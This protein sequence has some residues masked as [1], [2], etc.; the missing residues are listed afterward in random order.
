MTDL[1]HETSRGSPPRCSP[2]ESAQ[3]LLECVRR[4]EPTEPFLRAIAE[5]TTSDLSQIRTNRRSG[6][7]FWLNSYN[8][9]AQI[10]LE[11]CL[12]LFD[13]RLQFFR[14]PV[15]TV[16]GVELSLDD[17]EHGILRG[18][19][20]KYGLGYIPRLARTGLGADY[21]LE[22]DPR[23]HFALNCGAAS[24]PAILSYDPMTVDKAL[25]DATKIHLD[26]TVEYNADRNRVR[27]PRI[28]LWFISDFGGR[29]GIRNLLYDFE[30][31]PPGSSPSLRFNSYDWTKVPRRFMDRPS[32][33]FQ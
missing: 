7:A 11:S 29:S 10:L 28:C 19:R 9:A 25:N 24:C 31:V 32:D 33:P 22:L 5:A 30:Q 3:R 13:S 6:L 2:T 18:G 26:Q 12:E 14:T 4:H 23:I 8:A 27:L 21:Q 20:S 1:S 17:I 15:L 16:A